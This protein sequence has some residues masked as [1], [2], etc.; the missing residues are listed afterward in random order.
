ML[1]RRNV[2]HYAQSGG[3]G[4]DVAERNVVLTYVLKALSEEKRKKPLLKELAF[5]GGTCLRKIYFGKTTRFSMDLDFTAV[6]IEVEAFRERLSELLHSREHYGI[7]FTIDEEFPKRENGAS[8]YGAIINYEHEWM[9]SNFEINVSF[10]EEPCLNVEPLPLQSELYFRYCE[11]EPFEVPCLQKE[12]LIAEKI[13]AAFQRVRSRDLYDLYVYANNTSYNKE[14]VKAL[15]VIKCWNVREPFDPASLLDKIANEKYDWYDLHRLV[16]P[17]SLPSKETIIREATS[18]YEYLM[19][20]NKEL[21]IIIDDS[22]AHTNSDQ[23]ESLI[24]RLRAPKI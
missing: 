6:G 17:N 4:A 15:A 14:A 7:T 5:K 2:D 13:R 22:R 19:E 16:R 1:T 11:F 20:I 24:K 10:R 3:I 23:V 9:S 21:G 12:E 18:N 8:S